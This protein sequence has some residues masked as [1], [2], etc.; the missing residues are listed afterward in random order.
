[1]RE[2]DRIFAVSSWTRERV[3]ALGGVDPER[4]MI[5]P[6]TMDESRFSVGPKP[7]GLAERYGISTEER[8][9]LSVARLDATERYKGYDRLVRALPRLN[10]ECGPI[11][12]VLV[13]EGEDKARVDALAK[14]L[15]VERLVTLAGFVADEELADHYRLADVFALPSTCEGFGIVFLESMSC[16]T[17][18]VAGNEDGS[19]DALDNGC[20]GMLVNPENIESI[21]KGIGHILSGDGPDWWFNRAKLHSAVVSRF[22]RTPFRQRLREYF[23]V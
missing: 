14:I 13:G 18:V 4:V 21:T 20:L 3:L 19:V 16:G 7:R 9:I 11:R 8:V 2:A 5:L 1:M 22:G 23:P 12:F 15:G 6:N 17:P 10:E